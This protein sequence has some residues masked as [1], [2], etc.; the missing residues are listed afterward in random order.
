MAPCTESDDPEERRPIKED[1]RSGYSSGQSLLA[2]E[3]RVCAWI[4]RTQVSGRRDDLLETHTESADL[5]IWVR[6]PMKHGES[7]LSFSLKIGL[8]LRERV[9]NE[10]DTSTEGADPLKVWKYGDQRS[11]T[12]LR[13]IMLAEC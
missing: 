4:H 2:I 3:E 9:K 13:S 10:V 12:Y 7:N 5:A 11:V 8:S 6:K 1:K